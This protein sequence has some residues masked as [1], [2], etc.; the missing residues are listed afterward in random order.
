MPQLPSTGD[1]VREL[2][3]GKWTWRDALAI[4][5]LLVA[6]YAALEAHG[7]IG[8]EPAPEAVEVPE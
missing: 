7:V 1:A 3:D 4:L 8:S 2:R 5:A 6:A